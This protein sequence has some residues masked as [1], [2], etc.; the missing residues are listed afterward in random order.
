MKF[1]FEGLQPCYLTSQIELIVFTATFEVQKPKPRTP[2]Q[3]RL[4]LEQWKLR[5]DSHQPLDIDVIYL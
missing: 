1:F 2:L 4:N 5:L 3:S